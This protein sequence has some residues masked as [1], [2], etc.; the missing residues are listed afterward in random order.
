[1]PSKNPLNTGTVNLD[2]TLT[3]TGVSTLTGGATAGGT[4]IRGGTG[5]ITT[6][7]GAGAVPVT[8]SVHE[9]TTTGVGDALTLADGTAGQR[10][11]IVY[12]A[13][14]AGTDTA[15]LTPTTLAGGTTI[16]YNNLG[17]TSDL[18]FSSTGG[19]HV[20]GL[21]GAAAVA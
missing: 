2:E 11:S 10:L 4:W 12:V 15:I 14:G 20:L 9:V 17:D 7:S 3:V 16:T 1:M 8:G 5:A 19:W 18:V 21:G 13:E 6:T